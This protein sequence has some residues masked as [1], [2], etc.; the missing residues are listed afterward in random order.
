MYTSD[1]I[2]KI[3]NSIIYI[4]SNIKEISKTKL[5]KLLYLLDEISI[6]KSGIPFLNLEYRVW[7]LGPVASDVFVELSS[8]SS[9][10]KNY[11]IRETSPEGHSFISPKKEFSD[12][13]FSQNELDLLEF[14]VNKFKYATVQKLISITHCKQS[15]WYNAAIKNAVYELLETEQIGATDFKVNM[16]ELVAYDDRKSALYDD[17]Q[18]NC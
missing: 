8:S 18:E 2:D 16:K 17:Y 5:L 9:F 13:E 15:P 11:I 4:S 6:K 12:D 3:G 14:I 7:K 10:L 1:Q